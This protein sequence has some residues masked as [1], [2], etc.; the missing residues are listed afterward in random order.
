MARKVEPQAQALGNDYVPI[1][2]ILKSHG[3]HGEVRVFPFSGVPD[4]FKFYCKMVAVNSE[5]GLSLT[6]TVKRSRNQGKFVILRFENLKTRDEAE[7]LRGSQLL[8]DKHDLPPLGPGEYYWFELKGMRVETGDGEELGV[9]ASIFNTK[10]HDIMVVTNR[11]REYL[12]PVHDEV[13]ERL[14]RKAGL[15]VIK[16]LPG[17]LE[18]NEREFKGEETKT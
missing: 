13:I 6:L 3:V 4:N 5:S 7:T 10:A 8:V 9:V 16:P 14:D 12:I 18:L 1:G 2:K 15:V 17:L 11:G